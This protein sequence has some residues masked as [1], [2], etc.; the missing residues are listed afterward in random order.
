MIIEFQVLSVLVNPKLANSN[1]ISL[2]ARKRAQAYSTSLRT[3]VGAY[4]GNSKGYEFI[5]EKV[6]NY[7]N[8]RDGVQANPDN[9]FLTNGASEGVRTA[10][11]MLIRDKKD[12]VLIPIPQY[13][14]YSALI[15]L[16]GGTQVPYYLDETQNWAL[17]VKDLKNQIKKA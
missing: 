6:A 8:S 17:D 9:I 1:D 4:T 11:N 15:T 7:I 16:M 3:G 5:R 2:D 10:F 13:P 12:G 14:L